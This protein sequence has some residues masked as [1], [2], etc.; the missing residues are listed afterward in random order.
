MQ[1]AKQGKMHEAN[2][3]FQTWL[4]ILQDDAPRGVCRDMDNDQVFTQSYPGIV[5]EVFDAAATL[6][7]PCVPADIAILFCVRL[8]L[9]Q[10]PA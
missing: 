5:Y 10:H 2:S 9:L 7:S 4:Y 8:K 6:L 1:H 3:V